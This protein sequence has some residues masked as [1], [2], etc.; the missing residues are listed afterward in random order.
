MSANPSKG[1]RTCRYWALGP[2]CP[3]T[4]AFGTNVCAYA[5]WDTGKL[6]SHFEQRG[7]CLSWRH[8]GYCG[9]GIGC[10]YEHRQTGVTGLFQGSMFSTLR[11]KSQV[12]TC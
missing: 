4:D 3:N 8:L 2:Q 12:L 11:P 6:A 10:W 9:K 7:T 5:H 1:L